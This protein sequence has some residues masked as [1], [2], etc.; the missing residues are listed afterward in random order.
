M[1]S[2]TTTV[3]TS[4]KK[5]TT[6]NSTTS[7]SL[8]R[9]T[10]LSV[11]IPTANQI[12]APNQ[13]KPSP[14]RT[15]SDPPPASSP[16]RQFSNILG[17]SVEESPKSAGHTPKSPKN[18]KF[19]RGEGMSLVKSPTTPAGGKKDMVKRRHSHEPRM[20]VYTECGRHSDDWLF[21]GFSVAGVVKKFWEKRNDEG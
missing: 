15:F 6:T 19:G 1:A 11:D 9:P 12:A 5:L 13:T 20:N 7:S 14:H 17:R 10:T 2:T 3:V 21:G 8:T 4:T 16:S 18:V